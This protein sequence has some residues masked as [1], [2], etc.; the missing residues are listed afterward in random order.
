MR[1]YTASLCIGIA[2]ILSLSF[3]SR[4]PA[5]S[6]SGPVEIREYRGERLSP[7]ERTYDNSIKG[8][9]KVDLEAYRLSVSGLVDTPLKLKY[10][11]VLSLPRVNRAV[12]LHC[13]EGW[14]EHL[15]FEGIRLADLFR[16]ASVKSGV[17]TVIFRAADGYASSLPY[18]DV[19]RLDL[20]LASKINGIVL[21]ERRGF[22]FQVVAQSKYGYKWVRWVTSIELTDKPFKG[23]WETRGYSN[24]ADVKGDR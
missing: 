5:A 1:I 13:V 22:P 18:D 21:D 10:R 8:P 4:V 16:M 6:S 7:Y 24:E 14:S 3:S 19:Q 15:L 2:L 17:K 12:T 20:M 23:F 11:E 9:Q